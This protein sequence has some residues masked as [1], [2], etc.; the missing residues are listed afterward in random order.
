MLFETAPANNTSSVSNF[1]PVLI[2]LVRRAMPTF[3]RIR[4]MWCS[5]NEWTTGLI[6]AMKA[7]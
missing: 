2:S 4:C 1:D 3:N 7:R 6:F 5:G